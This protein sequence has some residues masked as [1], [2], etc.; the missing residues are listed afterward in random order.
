MEVAISGIHRSHDH[1]HS[2]IRSIVLWVVETIVLER[3]IESVAYITPYPR[4]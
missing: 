3:G 2:S 1:V 4:S